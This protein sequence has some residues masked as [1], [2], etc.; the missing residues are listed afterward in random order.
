MIPKGTLPTSL[1]TKFTETHAAQVNINEYHDGSSHRFALVTSGRRKWTLSKRLTAF[2]IA[3]LRDFQNTING[4]AF[5][6]YN[7]SET[8][9]PF[10]PNPIGTAGLYLVRFNNDWS[11]V[12]R[13]GR[14]DLD[15]E[16]MEVTSGL[17][18]PD[19]GPGNLGGLPSGGGGGTGGGT[20]PPPSLLDLP[21]DPLLAGGEWLQYNSQ[22]AVGY[23][24]ISYGGYLWS[25]GT[26]SEFDGS[27]G[28][29][30]FNDVTGAGV[31]RSADGTSWAK[32]GG[33]VW[34]GNF[35][36]AAYWDGSSSTITFLIGGF[37]SGAEP[38]SSNVKLVDFDMAT[39]SY[40]TPTGSVFLTAQNERRWLHDHRLFKLSNGTYRVLYRVENQSWDFSSGQRVVTETSIDIYYVDYSGGSWSSLVL[41]AGGI[42]NWCGP[43]YAVQDGDAVHIVYGV[44]EYADLGVF[45]TVGFPQITQDGYRYIRIDADGS[46]TAPET[47]SALGGDANTTWTIQNGIVSG[48]NIIIPASRTT[49]DPSSF[50]T[51]T[52]MG[53]L[54]GTPKESPTFTW[55]QVGTG[56][57]NSSFG[58]QPIDIKLIRL[59]TKDYLAWLLQNPSPPYHKSQIYV[60]SSTNHGTSWTEPQLMLDLDA[61]PPEPNDRGYYNGPANPDVPTIFQLNIANISLGTALNG[62]TLGL[63]YTSWATYWTN[64]PAVL[65]L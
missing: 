3:L 43:T 12:S 19:T 18:L 5:Y 60:A 45:P 49:F 32:Q 65:G 46:M 10:S 36:N 17:G 15:I 50:A 38:N 57:I 58:S 13:V 2:Q 62:T 39:S 4:G 22:G 55:V 63:M 40:G 34:F 56:P 20:T 1:A 28:G 48:S 44:L 29:G 24:P 27:E 7:P 23:G 26:A 30:I 25:Y 8:I 33:D 59:G 35:P 61:N 21:I 47:I 53:V 64:A 6:F 42:G 54:I 14:S 41:V 11:Q 9:P 37:A 16:L 31:Y 52:N 51:T